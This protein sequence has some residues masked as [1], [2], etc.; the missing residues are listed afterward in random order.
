MSRI[1]VSQD[2][3]LHME[4]MYL[5]LE[6]KQK[7]HEGVLFDDD[8]ADGSDALVVASRQSINKLI[9]DDV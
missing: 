1:Y 8:A 4:C 5:D 2:D 7:M 3:V 6:Q 9:E